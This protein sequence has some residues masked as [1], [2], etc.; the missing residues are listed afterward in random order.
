MQRKVGPAAQRGLHRPGQPP[1]AGRGHQRIER[2]GVGH[3]RQRQQRAAVLALGL[4]LVG[5]AAAR[6]RKHRRQQLHHRQPCAAR[7]LRQLLGQG[8]HIH[9]QPGLL[10]GG[11]HRLAQGLAHLLGPGIGH[12]HALGQKVDA[13]DDALRQLAMAL[14][15]QRHHDVRQRLLRQPGRQRQAAD[16]QGL[17]LWQLGGAA[18]PDLGV[19]P[20]AQPQRIGRHRR[21]DLQICQAR[22]QVHA[23]TGLAIAPAGLVQHQFHVALRQHRRPHH[24]ALG[25]ARVVALQQR[26]RARQVLHQHRGGLGHLRRAVQR[27]PQRS[28]QQHDQQQGRQQQGAH[29]P[30]HGASLPLLQCSDRRISRRGHVGHRLSRC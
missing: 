30:F 13:A 12:H 19:Q 14:Q 10:V 17:H 3:Q 8:L 16:A 18:Q 7:R 6:Q 26:V 24:A 9:P 21:A 22:L 11:Q 29:K 2:T 4:G 5:R 15:P 28:G 1:L 25:A 23:D 20:A 27:Q